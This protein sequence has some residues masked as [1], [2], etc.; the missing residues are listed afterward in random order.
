MS[1]LQWMLEKVAVS[2]EPGLSNAQLM[3]TNEDLRPGK[4]VPGVQYYG[5]PKADRW[6][7]YAIVDPERRQWK[8]WNFVTFWIADSL[9]IVSP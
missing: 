4:T 9:N 3:L 5:R 7:S 6:N 8:W 1:K 2:H